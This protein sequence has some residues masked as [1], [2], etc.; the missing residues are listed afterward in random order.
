M[1]KTFLALMLAV[2][3]LLAVN[4]GAKEAAADLIPPAIEGYKALPVTSSDSSFPGITDRIDTS[5][6]FDNNSETGCVIEFIDV[7]PAEKSEAEEAGLSVADEKM[8]SV[9]TSSGVPHAMLA[10]A[11]NIEGDLGTAVSINAYATNDNLFL[12]WTQLSFTSEKPEENNG[13][14]I[15]EIADKPEKYVFYRFDITLESGNVFT[16]NE[17]ELYKSA[18][19]KFE[20]RYVLGGDIVP[21]ETPEI[22][23]ILIKEPEPLKPVPM[24]GLKYPGAVRPVPH[25]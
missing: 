21:G 5:V 23:R 12:D 15:F 8:L 4:A 11:V 10:F 3:A 20:Y 7:A 25:R 19:D 1:K 17:I 16:L 2:S 13:Y 9:H 22:E 18:K 14:Y 24:F 6:I